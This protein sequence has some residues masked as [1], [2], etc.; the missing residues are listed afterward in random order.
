M[1]L[2]LALQDEGWLC[3]GGEGKR[4]LCRQRAAR[5]KGVNPGRDGTADK[6]YI[7]EAVHEVV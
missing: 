7:L 6:I 1:V 3:F 5:S 4:G 2:N